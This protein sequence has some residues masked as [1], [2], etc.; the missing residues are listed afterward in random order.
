MKIK[1]T[2]GL[3]VADIQQR[4]DQGARFVFYPYTLSF[5]FISF[6][7]KSGVYF[8]RSHQKA[9]FKRLG[10]GMLSFL[11][12]WWAVP[13]GPRYTIA[14]IKTNLRGGK[15]VTD[16][17]MAVMNG[18]QLFEEAQGKKRRTHLSKINV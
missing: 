4:V 12:G 11:F 10:F 7:L 6:R 15:N 1:N 18:Y 3:S 8:V 13:K 14:A 5:G 2:R 17:V 9:I 16:E